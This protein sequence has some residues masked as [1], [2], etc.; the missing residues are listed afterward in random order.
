MYCNDVTLEVTEENVEP[1]TKLFDGEVHVAKI[2]CGDIGG[3]FQ[4]K[5]IENSLSA[6]MAACGWQ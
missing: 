2:S 5:E 6:A 3:Y 4:V 1:K